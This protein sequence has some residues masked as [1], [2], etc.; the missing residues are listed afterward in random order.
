MLVNSPAGIAAVQVKSFLDYNVFGFVNTHRVI[1]G[2]DGWLFYKPQFAEDLCNEK[3]AMK[4]VDNVNAMSDI[5]EG[6]NINLIVA[7]SPDKSSVYPERL[8]LRAGIA[9]KCKTRATA[10]WRKYAL[11][12]H[13]KI[14]D[15]LAAM[16]AVG[17]DLLKYYKEDTH[18]ND[19]GRAI[20]LRQLTQKV[21]G[22]DP[23]LPT[24]N[25]GV[26]E[27]RNGDLARM[28]RVSAKESALTFPDYWNQQF[29]KAVGRGIPN[30]VILHD[31]FYEG[32]ATQLK[33]LF[34]GTEMVHLDRDIQKHVAALAKKP[35]TI[36]VNS[37]ERS[38][39]NRVT[40]STLSWSSPLAKHV[41]E[42]NANAARHC[43][44]RQVATDQL[45]LRDLELKQSEWRGMRDAQIF[46]PMEKYGGRVCMRIR[47]K[48]NSESVS[49]LYLPREM[50]NRSSYS[51]GY[52]VR[53]PALGNDREIE[54]VLPSKFAGHKLR[55]DPFG[56]E[57][58]LTN[59]S[60]EV[61][62]FADHPANVSSMQ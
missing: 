57:G 13:S 37:V 8:G 59:L 42:R 55:F 34:P 14:I 26:L 28:L 52:S 54:V 31:S 23:G 27:H 4:A 5:A 11:Q 20:A 35:P 44:Y 10:F 24:I 51:E 61:G 25:A 46:I 62:T 40:T 41:V 39:F 6:A 22:T 60:V 33:M 53:F 29:R 18:W 12:V 21:T 16:L 58:D 7:V 50:A 36:I 48:T 19:Y 45:L 17:D 47:F 56:G 38:F 15:H 43:I 30:T 32:A 2:N 3:L 1:S 49:V 9:S